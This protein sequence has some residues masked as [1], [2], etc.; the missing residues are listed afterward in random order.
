MKRDETLGEGYYVGYIEKLI[1][2]VKNRNWADVHKLAGLLLVCWTNDRKVFFCGNGGSAGNS[3]HLANDFLYG[4]AKDSGIGIRVES[5]SANPSV[6]TC[7][8]N[9]IG[10]E[11]IYSQQV[12]VK[13]D[14][15]DILVVLSGSGNSENV[16]R[17]IEAAKKKRVHTVA[18]VG[19]EGGRCLTSADTV[20]HFPIND[21]QISEDLQLVVGHMCM[22]WLSLNPPNK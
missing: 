12:A 8:G 4:V 17:A 2:V 20:I 21:M 3:N 16:V 6:L 13:A 18:I 14:P 15:G 19:Y 11:N 9:D 1:S 5:L 22:Q 7:L 10:Y